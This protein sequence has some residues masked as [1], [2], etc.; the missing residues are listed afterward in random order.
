MNILWVKDGKLGHEKQVEALLEEIGSTQ[1][2]N[3]TEIKASSVL[4]QILE[5]ITF[6]LLSKGIDGVENIGFDLIIG[7]G[8]NTHLEMI[9]LKKRFK[10]AKAISILCPNIFFRKKF[11]YICVPNH[12]LHKRIGKQKSIF[13][14]GS[15][16]KIYDGP[17]EDSLGMFSIGGINKHYEF[18]EDYILEQI[19]FLASIHPYKIWHIFNS[20]RT[21]SSMNKKIKNLLESYKNISFEDVHNNNIKNKYQDI[22]HSASIRVITKDSVNMVYESLSSSGQSFLFDMDAK[23]SNKIVKNINALINERRIGCLD[24]TLMAD[25]LYN[26]KLRPQNKHFDV[27]RE[28]E[29][30]AYTILKKLNRR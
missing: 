4:N 2:I 29:K 26:L 16:S 23:N 19:C 11:D 28:V 21:P 14:E 9:N 24:K 22:L 18:D 7:A 25:G 17:T 6:G 15:L 12:D 1:D 13:F 3:I 27:M 20:R 8:S 5:L 30:L 10:K